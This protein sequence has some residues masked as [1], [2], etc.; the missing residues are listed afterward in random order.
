MNV[1]EDLVLKVAQTARIKIDEV[2]I[3]KFVKAFEEILS[4]F[5]EL[6]QVDTEN[7]RPSFHPIEKKDHLRDDEPRDPCDQEDV[8]QLSK[9]HKNGYFKGPRAMQ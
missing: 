6:E 7:V 5:S 3:P 9:H 4:L 1:D 2:D 8:L